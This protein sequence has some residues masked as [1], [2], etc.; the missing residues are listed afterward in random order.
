MGQ[1]NIFELIEALKEGR[2]LIEGPREDEICANT[3]EGNSSDTSRNID[4]EEQDGDESDE[5]PV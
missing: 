5:A 1:P 4:T 3:P 2:D